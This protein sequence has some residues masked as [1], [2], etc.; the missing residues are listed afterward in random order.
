MKRSSTK[1]VSVRKFISAKARA[2]QPG[3]LLFI[4]LTPTALAIMGPNQTDYVPICRHFRAISH[5]RW[6]KGRHR[7]QGFV[8]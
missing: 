8:V 7:K 3:L 2:V 5:G 6:Y 4:S 1:E